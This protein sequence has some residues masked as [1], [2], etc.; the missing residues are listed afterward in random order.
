M[1][2]LLLAAKNG[3]DDL[4]SALIENGADL[5]AE[6]YDQRNCLDI[7]IDKGHR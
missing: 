6:D 1:H 5:S 4:V 7:A 2:P 3:H